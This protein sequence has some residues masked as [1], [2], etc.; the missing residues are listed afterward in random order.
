MGELDIKKKGSITHW[1]WIGIAFI[2]IAGSLCLAIHCPGNA[3][4]FLIYELFGMGTALIFTKSA[5]LSSIK[6]KTRNFTAVVTGGIAIPLILFKINP[7]GSFNFDECSIHRTNISVIVVGQDQKQDEI[8]KGKGFVKMDIIGKEPR[9]SRIEETGRAFFENLTIG[10]SVR[11]DINFSEPF[12]SLKPDSIFIIGNNKNIYLPIHLEGIDYV[13]GVVV[14]DNQV[15][16]GVRIQLFGKRGYLFDTTNVNGY[17][18]F[19][20]PKELQQQK[21]EL[22]FTRLGYKTKKNIA[23]PET[24]EPLNIQMEKLNP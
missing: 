11:L 20:I 23:L 19:N 10:D 12:R 24:R 8:L 18:R 22:W 7:V 16:P 5:S 13:T 2:G 4:Y 1:N 3:A 9:E 15:L 17:F 14:D 6:F 21:Y